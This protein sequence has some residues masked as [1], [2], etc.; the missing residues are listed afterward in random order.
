MNT[1]QEHRDA[2]ERLA[3]ALLEYEELPGNEVLKIIGVDAQR[4]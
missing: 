2:L 3:E 4:A 1:L